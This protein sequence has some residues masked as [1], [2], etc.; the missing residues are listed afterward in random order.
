MYKKGVLLSSIITASLLLSGCGSDSDNNSEPQTNQELTT[1]SVSIDFRAMMGHDDV[2]CSENNQTAMYTT[3]DGTS[4]NFADFRFFVSEIAL[5]KA[6]GTKAPLTLENNDFQYQA[7]NGDH[8]ALLDFEDATGGCVERGNSPEMN[9]R[10]VGEVP[11]GEYSSV[12]FTLGVPFD[13]NHD[14]DSYVDVKALNHTKM[15]W[16]WQAGRKFTKIEVQS[17]TNSSLIWNFHLGSTG[18]VANEDVNSSV[19]TSE[20]AQPNRVK[21][22]LDNFDPQNNSVK[23]NYKHLLQYSDVTTDNGGAA[24]CM[25]SLADPECEPIFTNL[26]LDFTNQTGECVNDGDCSSTQV[27]FS[28]IDK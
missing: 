7:A 22:R 15:N 13:I 23:V 4:V 2:V 16:S 21:V 18:C 19:V 6:D 27:L 9:T 8:T 20:C 11:E 14:K 24:G 12:E 5:V 26:G 25:S 1:K 3:P 10:V 28:V 17:E